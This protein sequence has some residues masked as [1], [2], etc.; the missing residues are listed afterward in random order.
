[1]TTI[2]FKAGILA[3]DSLT[4]CIGSER[5]GYAKKIGVAR[6]EHGRHYGF[7]SAGDTGLCQRFREWA[8]GGMKGPPPGMIEGEAKAHGIIIYEDNTFDT[9]DVSTPRYRL[10]M[11]K[12]DDGE[13]FCAIGSGSSYALGAL[14]MGA[15]AATAL[16]IARD[17]DIFT[18]GE[19]DIEILLP[20]R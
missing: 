7:G 6:D 16:R 14:A 20:E 19:I 10:R 12:G 4:V 13:H 17:F 5:Y 18:G 9:Y 8:S 1:M 2:A 3:G 15:N 11:P